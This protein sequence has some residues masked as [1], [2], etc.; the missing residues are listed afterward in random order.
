MGFTN[1]NRLTVDPINRMEG[2]MGAVTHVIAAEHGG[3][4]IAEAELHGNLFRGFET[5]LPG[6]WKS[7]S[8]KRTWGRDPRDAM[9]ITQRICGVCPIG[10]G[11]TSSQ[12][13]GNLLG[14]KVHNEDTGDALPAN[15]ATLRNLLLAANHLMSHI[16]HFYHLVALDYVNPG[17]N[18][19]FLCPR[20]DDSYYIN[21]A[22]VGAFATAVGYGGGGPYDPVITALLGMGG[23]TLDGTAAA[24]NG[25]LVGQYLKALDMRRVAHEMLAIFGGKGPHAAGYTPGGVTATVDSSRIAAYQARL[26]TLKAFIGE[27]LDFINVNVGTMMFDTVAAAHMFPEY[28]WIGNSWNHFM[29]YGWGESDT[30][31]N[32]LV[33]TGELGGVFGS[34]ANADN[35][36]SARGR[37]LN[38]LSGTAALSVAAAGQ[39]PDGTPR[40]VENVA[41]SR[42][43]DATAWRHP[44]SGV[45]T[46]A[47][48]A[49]DTKYSWLKAP[50]YQGPGDTTPLAYEVGPLSRMV[51]QGA[52]FA[53]LLNVLY[54][55]APAAGAAGPNLSVPGGHPYGAAYN[56][57]GPD[58][59]PVAYN[60]DSIL[61]R[62]AA[63]TVETRVMIDMAQHE[64]NKLQAGE[65]GA[66]DPPSKANAQGYGMSEASRGALGHWVKTD[67]KGRIKLYQC[68]VPTTWNGS[69][70]DVNGNPGAA[71]KSLEN[72]GGVWVKNPAQPIEIIRTTH[73]Y[74]FCIAC[75]VHVVT[76]S[77]EVTKVVVPPLP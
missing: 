40:I 63:R 19:P 35:R 58:L 51:V 37:K 43:T 53:G 68:V 64:L 17:L 39:D 21:G 56:D 44:W 11:T 13:I 52:Y 6:K 3:L 14:Y 67:A 77:G 31:T 32:P 49:P 29:A 62:I 24:I 69:P 57:Q 7:P 8:G 75:A 47:P 59:S 15:A 16:L 66:T 72:N 5:I 36:L 28:F 71:E 70:R 76:P 18:K 30:S 48:N 27:P 22:R 1:G 20:Y 50:R 54:P 42:F 41:H 73:S 55:L 26:D 2:H 34:L 33:L 4:R 74:D 38:A 60:G 65:S 9:I 61:D 25:Y 46:P 12:N 23:G 45:T 10:H